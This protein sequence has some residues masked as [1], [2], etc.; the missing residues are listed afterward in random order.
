MSRKAT[1]KRPLLLLARVFLTAP[2]LATSVQASPLGEKVIG[3]VVHNDGTQVSGLLTKHDFNKD[4]PLSAINLYSL[5]TEACGVL[6]FEASQAGLICTNC[7]TN[8]AALKGCSLPESNTG[9]SL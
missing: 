9:W 4:A 8:S 7:E 3:S 5:S 2:L 1:L 6:K